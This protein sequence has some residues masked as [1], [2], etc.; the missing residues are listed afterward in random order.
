MNYNRSKILM[1]GFL[2]IL[3]SQL[4]ACYYSVEKLTSAT[5]FELSKDKKTYNSHQLD[6]IQTS[7]LSQWFDSHSWSWYPVMAS[8]AP[9]TRIT[10]GH[11][12]GKSS[13]INLT[14]HMIILNNTERRLS[15][16]ELQDLRGILGLSGKE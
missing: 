6:A 4:T 5:V 11:E 13:E 3:F 8:Y 10:I 14:E 7:K 1:I 15:D 16:A 12:S 9:G 2:S